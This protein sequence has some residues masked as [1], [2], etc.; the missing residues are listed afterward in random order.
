[1]HEYSRIIIEEYCRK[2]N[3]AKHRRLK[4]LVE[5]SYDIEAVATDDDA[6]FLEGVILREQDPELR[7]AF[8]ELDEFLFG[9]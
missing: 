1:M 8:Q 3:S 4:Y 2:K 9:Y 5:L 7:E 6:I